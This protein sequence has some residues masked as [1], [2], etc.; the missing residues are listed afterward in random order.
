MRTIKKPIIILLITLC[1]FSISNYVYAAGDP[2]GD[3]IN[4]A[5]NFIKN[6]EN[7]GTLV[8]T[9][10]MKSFSDIV[11][12]VLVSL[13]AVIAVIVGCVLGI[14]YMYSSAEDKAKTKENLVTYAI[15]CAVLH[16]HY[17]F[18]K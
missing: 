8:G 11:Y 1:F 17:K 4:D 7:Q 15:G 14:Q 9:N 10:E 16:Y 3:I 18:I 2:I 13:G 12:I 5:N 6:G